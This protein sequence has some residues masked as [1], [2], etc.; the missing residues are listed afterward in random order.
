MLSSELTPRRM[1]VVG[2]S[3]TFY[4][5]YIIFRFS[6]RFSPSKT[7]MNHHHHHHICL[8]HQNESRES[9]GDERNECSIVIETHLNKYN[10]NLN[11]AL[12][13]IEYLS[14]SSSN[15]SLLMTEACHIDVQVHRYPAYYFE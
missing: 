2:L 1:V 3:S 12:L 5:K 4:E 11:C 6:A 7:N 14:F 13:A 9:L 10:K 15:A 8:M